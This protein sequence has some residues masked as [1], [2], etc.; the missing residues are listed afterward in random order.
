MD[1]TVLRV[2]EAG[3]VLRAGHR[4]RFGAHAHAEFD[5]FALEAR[6]GIYVVQWMDGQLDVTVRDR[7]HLREGIALGRAVSPMVDGPVEKPAPP[8]AYDSV[9]RNNQAT[10]LV[11]AQG[12]VLEACTAA[13]VGW[14]GTQLVAVPREAPRVISTSEEALLDAHPH[15]FAWFTPDVPIPLLLVNAVSGVVEPARAG[16]VMDAAVKA[17]L[18]ATLAATTERQ[19][20]R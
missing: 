8:C 18:A 14:D 9:R 11:D 2:V 19:A 7:P 3:V 13:V 20:K 16:P 17:Q 10:L 6:P 15:R 12:R 1:Y 5:A 4:R